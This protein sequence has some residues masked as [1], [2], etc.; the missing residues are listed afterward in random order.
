MKPT[1]FE[2]IKNAGIPY[3]NH[4]SDLYVPA[5][6]QTKAI[7]IQYP[8][9]YGNR[10]AFTNCVEGGIWWDIPFA[11][12]PFWDRLEAQGRT[13]AQALT[14]V[15]PERKE[16]HMKSTSTDPDD[17]K[18]HAMVIDQWAKDFGGRKV[19]GNAWCQACSVPVVGSSSETEPER[20]ECGLIE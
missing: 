11:Y 8:L 17:H 10:Q 15:Q 18:G 20:K 4:E 1:L 3:S 9:E 14:K 19:P 12:Q 5:N 2:A 16:P 13:K 7:L 6:E